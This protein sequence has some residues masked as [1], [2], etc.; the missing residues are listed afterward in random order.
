M[1]YLKG[2]KVDERGFIELK[3]EA[4]VE[5]NH[6]PQIGQARQNIC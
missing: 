3:M 5:Q 4:V 6:F 2:S 1:S